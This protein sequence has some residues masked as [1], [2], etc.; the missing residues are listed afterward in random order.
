[1]IKLR[2]GGLSVPGATR[3]WQVNSRAP[4][5]A[6]RSPTHGWSLGSVVPHPV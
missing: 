1:M 2:A 3:T 6:Q 5:R 4:A